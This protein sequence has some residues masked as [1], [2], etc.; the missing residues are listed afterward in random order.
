[1]T[2]LPVV[3]T[4]LDRDTHKPVADVLVVMDRL[5]SSGSMWGHGRRAQD[6]VVGV[7]YAFTDAEGTFRLPGFRG[8][9]WEYTVVLS[10]NRSVKAP[11]ILCAF[12]AEYALSTRDYTDRRVYYPSKPIT[13]YVVRT[14]DAARPLDFYLTGDRKLRC[15]EEDNDRF[16]ALLEA[17]KRV[18]NPD[19]HALA[20][21]GRQLWEREQ[22][23][24]DKYRERFS[25][26]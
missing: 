18:Q 26:R 14:K 20:P 15:R 13:L 22:K 23:L 21:D 25:G 1:V 5:V 2:T 3:G 8:W 7:S 17:W 12:N 4:V 16:L 6:A 10:S 9:A 24:Y 19:G 11:R